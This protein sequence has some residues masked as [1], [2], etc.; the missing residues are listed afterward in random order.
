LLKS[1]V[2][3]IAS[4]VY[5]SN[6]S[7]FPKNNYSRKFSL[8]WRSAGFPVQLVTSAHFMR[9]S[10]MKAAHAVISGAA[11]RKSGLASDL[12]QTFQTTPS[13]PRCMIRCGRCSAGE[14]SSQPRR[15][16]DPAWNHEI[17]ATYR[18]WGMFSPEGRHGGKSKAGCQTTGARCILIRIQKM[19]PSKAFYF[20]RMK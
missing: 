5:R 1:A 18:F 9:L 11:Y 14:P 10:L 16:A 3:Q 13:S 6:I 17:G 4:V 8:I 19:A 20:C 12:Y 7:T 15:C 2:S